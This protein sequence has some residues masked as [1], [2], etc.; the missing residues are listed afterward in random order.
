MKLDSSDEQ[1]D[2]LD[3]KDTDIEKSP[4]RRIPEHMVK[5]LY[6]CSEGGF[7]T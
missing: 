7:D 5:A 2:N 4:D 3:Q 6:L 1:Q